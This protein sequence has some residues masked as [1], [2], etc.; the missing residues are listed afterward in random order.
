MVYKHLSSEPALTG[1]LASGQFRSEATQSPVDP[2]HASTS[3]AHLSDLDLLFEFFYNDLFNVQT[4]SKSCDRNPAQAPEVTQVTGPTD[5]GGPS[6]PGAP[7]STANDQASPSSSDRNPLTQVRDDGAPEPTP[8]SAQ[9]PA[10]TPVEGALEASSPA[11]P[12]PPIVSSPTESSSTPCSTPTTKLPPH[13]PS[14]LEAVQDLP[15]GGHVD[16]DT[17]HQTYQPHPHT[18]KWTRAHPLHQIIGDPSTPVQTRSTTANDCLFSSFLSHIEPST[19]SEALNDPDWV[20]A[21]QEELNQFET[22]KVWRLV[23][24]P[25][26]KTVIGTKWIFKNKKDENGIIVRNKARLV[27]KG[28]RQQEG[29][30]YDETFAPVARIEAIRMFLAY[31]AHKNFIV[32]QMDVK[33]AFLN[34]VLKEEVYVSQPEGFVSTENPH[35]VYF[36]DK[37]L[38]GL[39]QAPRAW[40]DAL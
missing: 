25:K 16:A 20:I 14:S 37:A 24:R 38:Y 28:Y 27:A 34:D 4:N 22:L 31:A 30:D 6:S 39:K 18:T 26:N 2:H 21:M 33:S 36:L 40:Y 5:S 32:F 3:R 12:E 11:I 29:I 15:P 13:R 7:S 8:V 10:L 19:V 23:S 35:Y 9:L 17:S 1:V